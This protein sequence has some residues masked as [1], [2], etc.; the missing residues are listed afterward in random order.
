MS[1]A[2]NRN[3]KFLSNIFL[4]TTLSC[5]T[6]CNSSEFGAAGTENKGSKKQTDVEQNKGETLGQTSDDDENISAD[7]PVEVSGSFLT[8]QTDKTLPKLGDSQ[9]GF[10]CTVFE[11]DGR[12]KDLAGAKFEFVLE[13]N[14]GTKTAAIFDTKNSNYH[15]VSSVNKASVN[16]HQ[17]AFYANGS[18]KPA[19]KARI[20]TQTDDFQSSIVAGPETET[21][22]GIDSNYH[23]GDGNFT[24]DSN[25]DCPKKLDGKDVQGRKLVVKFSV[26]SD[27]AFIS[28]K[29]GELCGVDRSRNYVIVTQAYGNPQKSIPRK[30]S[31]MNF[32]PIK[33]RKGD[34]TFEIRSGSTNNDLDDF[35]V[36]SITFTAKGS[37]E[38]SDPGVEG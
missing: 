28:A 5:F 22:F 31:S 37:V 23:I 18:D 20:D 30:A 32:G 34:Y 9:I 1:L 2:F 27:Y 15:G 3:E 26:K 16:D 25:S 36:G 13:S 24:E 6:N 19:L 11:D 4:I 38:F 35:V 33:I 7:T 8:C 12:K 10:G 14:I 29:L 21:V 17:V